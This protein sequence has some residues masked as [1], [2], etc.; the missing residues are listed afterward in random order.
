MWL[1]K[2]IMY[3]SWFTEGD[4]CLR[5]ISDGETMGGLLEFSV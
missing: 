4:K 1:D 3:G 2:V 5:V